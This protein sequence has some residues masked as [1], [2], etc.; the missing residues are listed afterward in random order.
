M[1][2][3]VCQFLTIFLLGMQ[4]LMVR[5][6]NRLGAAT[7]SLMIGISQFYVLSVIS[8]MGIDAVGTFQ[9]IAFILAGPAG[10]VA[11][12]TAHPY[13]VKKLRGRNDT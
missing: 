2:I 7:G 4:S 6:D 13:I 10:I 8:D 9:W 5:D 3:F 11:S 12:M 1:L